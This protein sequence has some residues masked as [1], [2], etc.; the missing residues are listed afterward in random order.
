MTVTSLSDFKERSAPHWEGKVRCLSCK[1]E[2]EARYPQQDVVT[3]LECPECGQH[4][5]K[6]VGTFERDGPT[7]VC[8]CGND[9][10]HIMPAGA[11]CP[12]CGVW[13][14]PEGAVA[15]L[16][17]AAEEALSKAVAHL[18]SHY[19]GGATDPSA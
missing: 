14:R 4:D 8:N 3:W 12:C 10:F 7:W 17:Q 2:W 5:G 9:L 19:G 6:P 13:F 16:T 11:Y 18:T 1:H 15:A